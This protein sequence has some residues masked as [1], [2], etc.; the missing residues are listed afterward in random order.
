MQTRDSPSYSP[1][2]SPTV[3]VDVN[4]AEQAGNSQLEGRKFSTAK[5]DESSCYLHCSEDTNVESPK[6][7]KL[8][9]EVNNNKFFTQLVF[10]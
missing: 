6:I 10:N 3:R 4:S 2:G 7:N 1:I 9:A 8:K 5:I